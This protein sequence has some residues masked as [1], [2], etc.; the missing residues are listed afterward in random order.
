MPRNQGSKTSKSS[1]TSK[2]AHDK[3]K[4]EILKHGKKKIYD[5]DSDDDNSGSDNVESFQESEDEYSDGELQNSEEDYA[6]Q[7]GGDTDVASDN[8]LGDDNSN[9]D[10]DPDDEVDPNDDDK[11]DPINEMDEPVDTDKELEE[12]DAEEENNDEV[13]DAQDDDEDYAEREDEDYIPES[14]TCHMKNLNKDFLVLDED[15]SNMYG[16]MPSKKIANEDRVSDPIITYYEMVRIIGTRA[17]QFNFGAE[18]LVLGLE[19]LHPAK[20]AYLE[21]VARMTPFI[22]RR[23]LPGKKYEEWR[24]DELEIIHEITDE[25]FVPEKFDWDALM[26]QASEYTQKQSILSDINVPKSSNTIAAARVSQKKR[27]SSSK[28]SDSKKSG[29]KK[30]GSKKSDSKRSESKR[31]GSKGSDSKRS[32]SKRSASKK[33]SSKKSKS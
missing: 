18:P 33:S 23:R 3:P 24:I 4:G 32:S 22:I 19:G 26:K 11:Y 6:S 30:F 17:Q 20:M 29:S 9:I 13:D 14:K 21:L 28:K 7:S 15:D 25:F 2:T 5:N 27:Q 8:E 16:K 12:G 10:V 31:S 1:K